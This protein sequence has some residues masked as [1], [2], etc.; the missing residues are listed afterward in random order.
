MEASDVT[1]VVSPPATYIDSHDNSIPITVSSV[2][3]VIVN[4]AAT[5]SIQPSDVLLS[6]NT[7]SVEAS[8]DQTSP[9]ALAVDLTTSPELPTF[10]AATSG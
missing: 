5:V 7:S 4:T 3:G 9:A 2:D 1:V 6:C 10:E 8:L